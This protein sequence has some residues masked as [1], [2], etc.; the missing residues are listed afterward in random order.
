[1]QTRHADAL[2]TKL[3][4]INILSS[5]VYPGRLFVSNSAGVTR[6]AGDV[7]PIGAPGLCSQLVV[8]CSFTFVTLYTCIIL[9]IL[10][11]L[12]CASVFNVRSWPLDYILFIPLESWFPCLLLCT[13]LEHMETYL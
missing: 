8:E 9:V 1:M 2:K 13:Y 12:F 3:Q 11:S 10:C 4:H 6:K 5:F 7:Y